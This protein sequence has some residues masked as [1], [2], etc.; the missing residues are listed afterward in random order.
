MGE[1][2]ETQNKDIGPGVI[3]EQE[4]ELA[5]N[6]LSEFQKGAYANCLSYLNKLETLRPKDLKVMHN[7]VVVECYKNDLKKTE[8]LRKSLNA[9][10]GQ[11]ST[12]DSTETIDD[13]EKCVMRYNQAVLL[14]HTKQYNAAIQIM[15]R[16][17]AFIEPMEESL[18]HK[19]CLLLIEL[20]IV[21][22]Q[23]DAA[24][25]LINYIESQL[26]STD[27]SKIS[28]VDKEG[29]IKS[30][31][32]QKEPKR[33]VDI[34]TDAF[35]LKLL[36]CKA[37]IY[38]MMH[39]LKL[40]KREW[41]TLVSLGTPVNISTVFLKANLEYLRGNYKKAIKLLNSVT[42]ENL[43]FKTC[44]ESSA[45]LY[46]NNMACLHLAM[47]KPNLASF[48]LRKALH[49]NKCALESVQVKDNDPL[50]SRPLC[51]LGGNKHYELMYS[52]GVS[53]LHAGHASLA[54]DCFMEAAQKLHNNPKL[55]L[56][57]AECC[58]YCHKPT[59]EVDFNIP[60]RRKD[61]VQKVVGTGIYRKIILASS[62]SK[63][64]KYH[65]EGFPSAI[66]QLTL[67]FA[68]LCLKNALFLLPNNN[69]LN[70]PIT[71][72]T[73][74][75][76]V[77][78]SLT[79]GHNLGSQHS[80]LM[81]QTTTIEALNLKISVLAASAYVCLCLGDY[82]IALEHA[83]ALLNTNKLPGAYRML[84][85]LYAAESLIFMDKISEAIEY[86]KPENIQDLSTSVLIPETQDKDKEK[87]DEVIS[88]PI[89]MW[90]PTTVPTGIAVLRYN[91][92]VAYAI[93][94]ELDKSGETL[95]QVWMSKGPDCDVP[96]HVIMLALYIEL[97]LGHAD[98]SRSIIKQHCPQYR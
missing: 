46:Y 95:K 81:S 38:L 79:A 8:L 40:C 3:T 68:S 63:D 10:C 96:I 62:L 86:L 49:E 52:L 70:V 39:Q 55:W 29:I 47:G 61:L 50:S 21:T 15:N 1:T 76:T 94:G 34:V 31:K 18:A 93:R 13:I 90:Y 14:Y 17:F 84:G 25:S 26:I 36:K 97:Q 64:I 12:I 5:Q 51:T 89:K 77:P 23:P 57:I 56:R 72:I 30:I 58:I 19:V 22:E 66:P 11:M 35:K 98:I 45:V 78:L 74:P 82:V 65:P 7:K 83:K 42:S 32:E 9:I 37:R 43:D 69:E 44:G 28:S 41:K 2:S 27:N 88:K 60:K 80:T 48:Y 24:L 6:A 16:L 92:A 4:R 53:L 59:N 33:E 91:L 71:P 87:S 85:N 54:F 73:A 67:E 75:Q 20:H